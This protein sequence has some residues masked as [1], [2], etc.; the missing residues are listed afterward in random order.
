[1]DKIKK[2][3]KQ[4][5]KSYTTDEGTLTNA[6][7]RNVVKTY[8]AK[9]IDRIILDGLSYTF[10]RV[11]SIY[12]SKT[13]KGVRLDENGK[14][15]IEHPID[16]PAT[17]KFG[18]VMYNENKLTDGYVFKIKM[19]RGGTNR[20]TLYEFKPERWSFKRYLAKMINDPEVKVD[21]PIT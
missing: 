8:Y 9:V 19:K 3:M 1:M 14:L 2:G 11:G 21:A 18:K 12:I 15:K 20:I 7:Y 4:F 17:K 6:Q 16:W 13:K 10:G 5:Y